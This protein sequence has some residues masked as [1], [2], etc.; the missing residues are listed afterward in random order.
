MVTIQ[1]AQN[2]DYNAANIVV[3][4]CG[5]GGSNAVQNMITSGLQGVKFV[6][7]NTDVQ[8][9]DRTQ[10]DVR[11]DIG[12]R[13]T[14]GLGAGGCPEIGRDA[15][16][17]DQSRIQETLN[18]AN[19]VFVTAGMGGGTGTGSAPVVAK[20]AKDMG[21]LTVG[22]VT[23]PFSFEGTP[24]LKNADAGIRELAKC[25]DSLIVI[26]NDKLLDIS[27]ERLTL[28]KGLKLADQVL[29]DAVRA[30]S[31][32]IVVPG[33][34]NVD[35]ADAKQI[36]AG[37]GRAVIGMGEATGDDRA[38]QASERA[39]AS[40]LLESSGIEGATALLVNIAGG[41]DLDLLEV[42][43]AM[44][45]IKAK[46][47]DTAEV[48][49]GCVID[50]SMGEKIKVT[51]IATGFATVPEGTAPKA[52]DAKAGL[53]AKGSMGKASNTGLL[54]GSLSGNS[55][56]SSEHKAVVIRPPMLDTGRPS[57]V[58]QPVYVNEAPKQQVNR[59]PRR[60]IPIADIDRNLPDAWF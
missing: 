49:F 8:V 27:T 7:A 23:K 10:V 5:G 22:V 13:A 12:K 50:P 53:D 39:M 2:Q 16:L 58:Q 30:I 19:M 51:L 20:I 4:G 41:E 57:T 43:D 46:A 37:K 28:K 24:R 18:G 15:A 26:P 48:I 21:A 25:V 9:L 55:S 42:R 31:D 34:I 11:L 52:N 56:I 60:S 36:M 3:F 40:H 14:A 35:F 1:M 29:H 32:I 44:A 17:E 45:N 33:L 54:S 59:D 38:V 6:I 47:A